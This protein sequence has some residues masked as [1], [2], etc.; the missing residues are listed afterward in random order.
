MT[1]N[2]SDT[3]LAFRTFRL[4]SREVEKILAKA[5]GEDVS[6]LATG[7]KQRLLSRLLARLA[8]EIRNPLSSLDIH[9]QLLEEDLG[10]IAPETKE[11]LSGRLEIIH[12]ELHRLENVVKQFLRLAGPS[13]LELTTVEI[14]KVIGHVCGL[15]QPEAAA[16]Q[17]EVITYPSANLPALKADGDQIIQALLNLMINALQAVEKHGRVEVRADRDE[18]FLVIQVRDSGPGIPTA[19]LGTIFEPYY[20]TKPEGSGIGLWIAQQIT[21]AHG[22][23]LEAGNMPVGGAVFTMRL[24]LRERG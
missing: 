6:N 2:Y 18:D 8:H 21:A 24:P 12:G 7:E 3:T 20:T 9:V 11:R 15:L 16:R 14:G 19:S 23:T 22:G 17:I 5:L 10:Q 4:Y 13:A 1:S